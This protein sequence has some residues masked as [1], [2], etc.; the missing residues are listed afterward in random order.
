M[1]VPS[2]FRGRPAAVALPRSPTRHVPGS[3]HAWIPSVARGGA[4]L[5]PS[6]APSPWMTITWTNVFGRC[7]GVHPYRTSS[8]APMDTWVVHRCP[9]SHMR[10]GSHWMR[11]D[12]NGAGGARP[13][14]IV[15]L[16]RAFGP[17]ASSTAEEAHEF[18]PCVDPKLRLASD[19][20]R[21]YSRR[22]ALKPDIS[23]TTEP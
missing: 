15:S 2:R 20:P 10:Q 23:T 13:A 18:L 4:V 19:V 6:I 22:N 8:S 7:D 21:N 9:G 17:T 16:R 3:R 1:Y 12:W 5:V 11:C 14:G